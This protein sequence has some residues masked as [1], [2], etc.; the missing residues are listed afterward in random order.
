[1]VT[2]DSTGL[3]MR[4]WSYEPANSQF[5]LQSI[6]GRDAAGLRGW[7]LASSHFAAGGRF[8]PLDKAENVTRGL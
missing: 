7:P 5:L 8:P 4:R 2:F 1:M 3:K 6:D